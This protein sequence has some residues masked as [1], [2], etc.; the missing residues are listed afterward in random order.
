MIL[1]G[2]KILVTGGASGIGLGLTEKFLEM[3]N[4]VIICGR[5]EALLR[6]V[7]KRLPEVVTYTCDLKVP[8]E[9]RNL[10]AW[11]SEEHPDLNV[12]VNNA[13]IQ[14]RMSVED[15][16]F[17]EKAR[18]EMVINSEAPLHLISLLLNMESLDTIINITSGLSF[19]PLG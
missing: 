15:R 8:V 18:E 1:T 10:A 13:G 11:L 5:R 2:K 14:Q 7:G 12:L 17:F 3:G 16:D 19:A 9:R 6:E 4:R